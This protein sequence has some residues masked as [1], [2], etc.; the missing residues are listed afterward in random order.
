MFKGVKVQDFLKSFK[1]EM[2][3]QQYL[4][5]IKWEKGFECRKCGHKEYWKGRTE[6]HARCIRCD[7]DESLTANTYFHKI[8]ISLQMAFW[9]VYE[10]A[11]LKKGLSTED[12]AKVNG[13]DQRTAWRFKNKVQEAMQTWLLSNLEIKENEKNSRIDG[14]ILTHREEDLNGLQR[15]N[16]TIEKYRS[17]FAKRKYTTLKSS[18]QFPDAIDPC[19]LIFG[20]YVDYGKDIRAWNFKGWLTGTHHHC[21]E[22]YLDLYMDE[23]SFKMN[24]SHRQE[25]IWHTVIVAMMRKP[26]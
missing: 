5:D 25:Y 22:K 6:F 23:F 3:C 16:L 8:Q 24:H 11:V 17:K 14:L 20:K 10:I 4:F 21:S 1:T 15:T 12:L 18:V 7:Y 9:M 19:H 2:K 13:I 26:R